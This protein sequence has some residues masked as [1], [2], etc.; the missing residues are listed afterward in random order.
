[1]KYSRRFI[2]T[3]IRGFLS[4]NISDF[5]IESKSILNYIKKLIDEPIVNIFEYDKNTI[6][7][8]FSNYFNDGLSYCIF[9]TKTKIDKDKIIKGQYYY[10]DDKK[11]HRIIIYSD[12]LNSVDKLKNNLNKLSDN[13]ILEEITHL[14]DF[15]RRDFKISKSD[16]N[17]DYYNSKDERFIKVLHVVDDIKDMIEKYGDAKIKIA[18]PKLYNFDGFLDY[19]A[20]K[21]NV[22]VRGNK[23]LVNFLY[24]HF[25]MV[26]KNK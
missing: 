25:N 20:E 16:A 23:R 4:E 21:S 3:T 1:M 24:N 14:L 2:N 6:Y 10:D 7:L 19:I 5:Y 13:T 9:F 17:V 15:R 22:N 11:Q 12:F 18:I 26:I 8:D